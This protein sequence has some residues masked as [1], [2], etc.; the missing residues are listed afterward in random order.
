MKFVTNLRT[1]VIWRLK[2]VGKIF[3]VW[4]EGLNWFTTSVRCI[5][6]FFHDP[7]FGIDDFFAISPNIIEV[8][9]IT[10]VFFWPLLYR[11]CSLSCS[12]TGLHHFYRSKWRLFY[13]NLESW[14][15]ILRLE[16]DTLILIWLS[17]F[18]GW[19]LF[20]E[21]LK[22]KFWMSSIFPRKFRIFDSSE[23]SIFD[24][25]VDKTSF[26]T[27]LQTFWSGNLK[28]EFI[29]QDIWKFQMAAESLISI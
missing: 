3:P 27:N 15:K 11:F 12:G 8:S 16:I 28:K 21:K 24:K 19:V 10:N 2:I 14:R 29:I 4:I 13:D 26:Y 1:I 23:K 20:N 6:M 25:S 7:I 18:C 9:L 22:L 5:W 17:S